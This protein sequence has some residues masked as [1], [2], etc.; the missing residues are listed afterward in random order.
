MLLKNNVYNINYSINPYYDLNGVGLLYF[1]SYPTI[2]DY[3][4]TQFFNSLDQ[5]NQWAD[6]YFTT[7]RDIFYFSNCNIDDII[8]LVINN[9]EFINEK[10]VKIYSSLIRKTDNTK[11]ADIFTIKEKFAHS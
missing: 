9:Y 3:C 4:E 8:C 2:S 6:E 7:A 5:I 10:R 11:M 1:A